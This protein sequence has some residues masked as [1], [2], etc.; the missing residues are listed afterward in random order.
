MVQLYAMPFP[1]CRLLPSDESA[2]T[3]GRCHALFLQIYQLRL[4]ETGEYIKYILNAAGGHG[5]CCCSGS[6]YICKS[7]FPVPPLSLL[8]AALLFGQLPSLSL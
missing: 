4:D 8:L 3:N 1:I 2:R 7:F 5:P 6:F